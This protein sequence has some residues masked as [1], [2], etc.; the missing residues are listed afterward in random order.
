MQEVVDLTFET[1]AKTV[2][3]GHSKFPCTIADVNILA[4]FDTG[5]A[6]SCLSRSFYDQL[7]KPPPLQAAFQSLSAANTGDLGVLG[8]CELDVTF[9]CT[10]YPHRFYVC[11][12]LQTPVICGMDFAN[13]YRMTII[14]DDQGYNVLMERKKQ[15]PSVQVVM[16]T[17]PAFPKVVAYRSVTIPG[18]SAVAVIGL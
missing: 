14:T 6:K 11:E 7:P 5:A 2:L 17:K 10:E 15:L 16:S 3:Q 9:G 4:L 12:H 18:R 8:I 13:K 1:K